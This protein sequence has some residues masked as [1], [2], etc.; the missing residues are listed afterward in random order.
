MSDCV[1]YH[2]PKCITSQKVLK[3]IRSRG[4]QPRIIE[5]LKTP[6][7]RQELDKIL[8]MAG[9]EPKAIARK[10]EKLY[11]GMNLDK[12]DLSRS[13]WLNLFTKNPSLI[14]RPIVVRGRKA[15]LARPPEKVQ[16]IL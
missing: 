9:L 10:K 15:V 2:N 8:K 5:Y 14:E 4:I 1:I 16:E 11:S 13:E 7:S 6:P 12:K 3:A